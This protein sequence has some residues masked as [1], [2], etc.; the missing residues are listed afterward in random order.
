MFAWE[1]M[2]IP[3]IL[4]IPASN[5][6]CI[7]W[8][9]PSPFYELLSGLSRSRRWIHLN[10][11]T[12]IRPAAR[13]GLKWHNPSSKMPSCQ[14]T[15]VLALKW[16]QLVKK[17]KETSGG[18]VHILSLFLL[19]PPHKLCRALPYHYFSLSPQQKTPTIPIPV[20]KKGLYVDNRST[21]VYTQ[22]KENIS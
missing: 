7:K 8:G 9:L 6:K 2:P 16:K 21:S 1:L 17:W 18:D 15:E 11:R 10:S 3:H 14:F 13:S 4:G 19:L 20:G 22:K 5:L 12:S